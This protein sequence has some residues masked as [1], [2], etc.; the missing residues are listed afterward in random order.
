MTALTAAMIAAAMVLATLVTLIISI[1]FD[2][3]RTFCPV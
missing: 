3:F 1:G 2:L